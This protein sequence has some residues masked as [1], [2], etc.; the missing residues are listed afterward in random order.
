MVLYSHIVTG[1]LFLQWLQFGTSPAL[2]W[3]V[4]ALVHRLLN[5]AT[6]KLTLV[7]PM[8]SF[9]MLTIAGLS[10]VLPAVF[11]ITFRLAGNSWDPLPIS[12]A[13]KIKLS[14]QVYLHAISSRL[15]IQGFALTVLGISCHKACPQGMC[16]MIYLGTC[17]AAGF[18]A[19]IGMG[20]WKARS[21]A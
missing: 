1:K 6:H 11:V 12:P 19:L 21:L 9:C 3:L 5:H 18:A 16:M 2:C 10:I 15:P 13:C 8:A 4:A 20:S 7:P 17:F 14:A